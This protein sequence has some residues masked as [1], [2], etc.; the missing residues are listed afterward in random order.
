MVVVVVVV[1]P[2]NVLLVVVV[3]VVVDVVVVAPGASVVVATL[4]GAGHDCVAAMGRRTAGAELPCDFAVVEL[5]C[6][7]VESLEGIVVSI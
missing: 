5:C 1:S 2:G 7:C 3:V 4:V 6:G